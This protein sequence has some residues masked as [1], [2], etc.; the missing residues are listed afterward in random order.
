VAC[1]SHGRLTVAGD[2]RTAHANPRPP[3]GQAPWATRREA[4]ASGRLD[5]P[6]IG[7]REHVEDSLWRVFVAARSNAVYT[8]QEL[9]N[10]VALPR[11]LLHLG[12]R[13]FPLAL[14]PDPVIVGGGLEAAVVAYP[15]VPK[16][17]G[18][19]QLARSLEFLEGMLERADEDAFRLNW[20][21][22][23]PGAPVE[24][25]VRPVTDDSVSRAVWRFRP[26][27]E[28]WTTVRRTRVAAPTALGGAV[29]EFF[30]TLDRE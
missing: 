7:I 18:R 5:N 1:A 30:D 27:M 26:R 15:A 13:E 8:V 6:T 20:D 25:Q 28:A 14:P 9:R 4:L 2:F 19:G 16:I 12:K 11:Y 23:F 22:D 21:L 10:A 17:E 3:R 24:A 29:E